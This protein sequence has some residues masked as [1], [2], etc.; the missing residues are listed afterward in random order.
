MEY[1]KLINLLDYG[2]NQSSKIRTRKNSKL[3]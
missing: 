1:Q 3:R 2:T